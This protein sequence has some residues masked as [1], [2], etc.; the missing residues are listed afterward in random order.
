MVIDLTEI[1]SGDFGNGSLVEV[2]EPVVHHKSNITAK[3]EEGKR[4]LQVK[5]AIALLATV[6]FLV[7]AFICMKVSRSV[8][9]VMFT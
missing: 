8:T 1:R 9:M 3:L 6:L 4:A 5:A 2:G 7:V